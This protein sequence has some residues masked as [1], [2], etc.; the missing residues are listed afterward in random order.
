MAT[1]LLLST[2]ILGTAG[3]LVVSYWLRGLLFMTIIFT[4][5]TWVKKVI[6]E[7]A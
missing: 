7:E 4:L 2:I 3:L 1:F 6:R 5:V